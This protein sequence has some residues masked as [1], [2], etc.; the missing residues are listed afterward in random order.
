VIENQVYDALAKY[1]GP[2]SARAL[3]ARTGLGYTSTSAALIRLK[4]RGAAVMVGS[5]KIALWIAMPSVDIPDGRGKTIGNRHITKLA[6]L[7]KFDP[8]PIKTAPVH[9]NSLAQALAWE[10]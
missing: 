3:G 1:K 2:I 6:Q 10:P 4:K 8:E 5:K 9:T 7:A